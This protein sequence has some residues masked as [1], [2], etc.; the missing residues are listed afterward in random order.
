MLPTATPS[1]GTAHDPQ[2]PSTELAAAVPGRR[3]YEAWIWFGAGAVLALVLTW[4]LVGRL[5]THV[6]QDPA[7][8]L[9]E[10]WEIAWSGH[11]LL[12]YPMRLFS[13]NA[14]WPEGPSL[15]FS[16]SQL[17]YL[18]ASL[19]GSGPTA[20]IVRY[21]L[22]FLFVYALAFAGAALLARELGARPA[23]AAVAGAAFAWAPWR[24]THNGHLNIL[25]TGGVALSLFLLASGY[26]RGLPWQ[27][28]AGWLVAAWQMTLGFALGIWFAYLLAALFTVFAVRWWRSGRP[29][30]HGMLRATVVGGA[31]FL[32]VSGL[33][34]LPYLEVIRTYPDA[35]RTRGEVEFFSPPPGG[36][37]A[38]AAENRFWGERTEIIRKTLPWVPEQA[39]FPGVTVVLLA[40]A[41][42]LWRDRSRSLRTGLAITIAVT[43]VLSLGLRLKGGR[44]TYGPLYDHLPGWQGMRTPGRLAFIWS[45]GLA[46]AAA[47]GAQRVWQQVAAHRTGSVSPWYRRVAA[48]ASAIVLAAVVLYEGTPRLPLAPV[49]PV[50]AGLAALQGPLVQFPADAFHDNTY[51]YWSTAGFAPMANG[52]TS[53]LPPSLARI[54]SMTG[55]PDQAS[56]SALRLAGYR[57][58]VVHLDLVPGTPWQD[59]AQR[60]IDGLGITRRTEGQL[61]VFD[62]SP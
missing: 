33:M 21:N 4:P 14:F 36:F 18:P 29:R 54:R 60:P 61:L 30:P 23:V 19:I 15:A 35:P 24:I 43:A 28:V 2:P 32:L 53:Y 3:W 39:L 16:D 7:D 62:L 26:R 52:N 44:F 6:P 10:A 5:S 37:L 17:G 9:A 51:M 8:P 20:A 47:L 59:V 45:L 25:S 58:V 42:L 55:F 13:A 31:I 22:L 50:P 41:G 56:V 57:T 34:A 46:V 40:G 48:S 38:A 11:A 49:P 27:V 12:N 1:G